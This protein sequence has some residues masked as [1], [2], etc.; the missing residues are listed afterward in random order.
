M[1]CL[2][3]YSRYKV[4]RKIRRT[5]SGTEIRKKA[6]GLVSRYLKPKIMKKTGFKTIDI[7]D[8][9]EIFSTR[10]NHGGQTSP[11][12]RLTYE[13]DQRAYFRSKILSR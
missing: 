6:I 1:I 3:I 10:K 4:E 5:I 2:F 11:R 9:N 7:Q 12:R 13:S 8:R